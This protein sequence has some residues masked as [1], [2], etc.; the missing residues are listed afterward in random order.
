MQ[1]F[2]SREDGLTEDVFFDV[3]GVGNVEKITEL[4][5]KVSAGF[6]LAYF[7]LHE[8]FDEMTEYRH[9]RRS[10]KGEGANGVRP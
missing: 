2:S 10:K 4:V 6:L 9:L 1:E 8:L 7:S 3:V 5:V